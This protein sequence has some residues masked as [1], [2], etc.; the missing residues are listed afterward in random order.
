MLYPRKTNNSS[1][2]ARLI[3]LK[4]QQALHLL[5]EW[6]YRKGQKSRLSKSRRKMHQRLNRGNKS[7]VGLVIT[8]IMKW[9]LQRRVAHFLKSKGHK[10]KNRMKVKRKMHRIPNIPSSNSLNSYFL[11][12]AKN[13]INPWTSKNNLK[14]KVCKLNRRSQSRPPYLSVPHNLSSGSRKTAREVTT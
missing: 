3:Q 14:R 8:L 9:I 12:T 10:M 13:P 2:R 5:R 6:S 4:I 1:P 11:K 7:L